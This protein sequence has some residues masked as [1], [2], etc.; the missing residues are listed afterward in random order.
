M[1]SRK[2]RRKMKKKVV[3]NSLMVL[4][5]VMLLLPVVPVAAD[6][7]TAP[8]N[9]V[10]GLFYGDGDD[11]YY[12]FQSEYPGLGSLYSYQDGTTL[13]LAV[14]VSTAINDNVFGDMSLT[15]DQAYVQSVGWKGQ[16]SQHTAKALIKSDMLHMQFTCGETWAWQQDYAYYS[17]GTWLSDEMGPDGTKVP[18]PV[19]LSSASSLQWN[20]NNN[21]GYGDPSASDPDTW[22]SPDGPPANNTPWDDGYPTYNSSPGWEWP[23]VYEMSLDVTDCPDSWVAQVVEAHNSPPKFTIPTP[24]V[25]RDYGDAPESY[26]TYRDDNGARHWLVDGGPILGSSVDAEIDS[27]GPDTC[28]CLDDVTDLDDEDGVGNG[29]PNLP[30]LIPG[31]VNSIQ[32]VG[33]AGAKVDAWIDFDGNGTFDLGDQ[34][35][36]SFTLSGGPDNIN[37]P[38]PPNTTTGDTWARFRVSSAGGLGPMGDAPDGEVEDYTLRFAPTAVTLASFKA[39][40]RPRAIV[41]R[42]ETATELDNLG[43]NLYRAESADG[44]FTQINA[45]LIPSLVPP[46]SPTGAEYI[47]R[48]RTA[49]PGVKY[50]YKLESVDVYG[51]GIFHGPV[52]AQIKPR[53]PKGQ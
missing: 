9:P 38:V 16:A 15:A 26:G 49:Q 25:I 44:P 45:S 14:V 43:F 22:K 11:A 40:A 24:P 46:G 13:Y 33:T 53:A 7:I 5:A 17:G 42:W 21:S 36:S 34:I 39:T 51:N 18:V 4:A 48:D 1:Y 10:N 35:A 28:A 47:F 20:F 41:L 6:S 31:Q 12:V 3:F 23:L 8:A 50:F 2:D 52:D 27:A 32:V 19:L 29:S 30:Q 37:F